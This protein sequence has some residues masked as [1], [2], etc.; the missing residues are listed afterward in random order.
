MIIECPHCGTR[1]RLDAGQL[2]DGRSMLKCARCLR[3]FPAPSSSLSPRHSKPRSTDDNLS[4]AF[5]DDD[6]WQAPELTAED[7]PE[8]A[9]PLN[10]VLTAEPEVLPT[11]PRPPRRRPRPAAVEQ[12]ALRFDA[13]A[14]MEP[15]VARSEAVEEAA[16]PARKV[17]RPEPPAMGGFDVRSVFIFLALVVSAYGA[18]T[19]SLLD[20]PDWARKLTQS[21][22]VIGPTLK[23]RSAGDAVALVDVQ[24]R[25]ER[26]KDGKAVLVITGRAVNRSAQSLRGVQ[27]LASLYDG[28]THRL[29]EQVTDCGSPL[30]ARIRDLSA[31]QV[32]ILRGI[33]P[34]PDYRI[35]PGGHCPFVTIFLDVPQGAAAFSAEVARARGQA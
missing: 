33:R 9:P 25:Y 20:D 15:E 23:E 7:V 14:D 13:D 16:V 21:L 10:D 19:W 3:V 28:G 35:A 22:P 31:H 12:P 24:G 5:D 11:R 2:A 6:E 4:F 30:E 8:E 27:I 1:F 32:S 17:R 29:D 26:T 18:L 34:P